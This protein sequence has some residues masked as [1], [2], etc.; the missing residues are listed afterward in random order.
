[1]LDVD[2]DL[3]DGGREGEAHRTRSPHLRFGVIANRR[4]IHV[5]IAVDL[6]AAQKQGCETAREFE[7]DDV[8]KRRAIF[9]ASEVAEISRHF[10]KRFSFRIQSAAAAIE[11]P[12][13]RRMRALREAQGADR[14]VRCCSHGGEI[15][16][17]EFPGD[18]RSHQFRVCIVAHDH[19]PESQRAKRRRDRCSSSRAAIIAV[20]SAWGRT[21][22]SR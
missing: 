13:I 15:I 19:L 22:R 14:N 20:S 2:E 7:V 1:M 6:D 9:G 10:D 3:A 16:V 4:H 11:K 12:E 18:G 5:S 8:L 21:K 17:A